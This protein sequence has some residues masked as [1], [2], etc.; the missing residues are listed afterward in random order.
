MSSPIDDWHLD[1]HLLGKRVLI[2]DRVESTNSLA[3]T[4]TGDPG[5]DG[6]VI[7]ANEQTAGRGQH[8]R[9]WLSPPGA[10]IWLS[11]LLFPPPELRRSVLL[12]AWAANSVCE[13]IA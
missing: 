5:S 6:L 11:V 8:G 1:T 3:A 10:G 9:S 12:A 4:F 13:T 2:Y 7:L